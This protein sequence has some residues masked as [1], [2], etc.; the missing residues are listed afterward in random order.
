M[1][2]TEMIMERLKRGA[3]A[4]GGA[5]AAG[6]VKGELQERTS[7]GEFGLAGTEIAG[8]VA[9]STTSNMVAQR[10]DSIPNDLLEYGGY[11]MQ[12]AGFADIGSEVANST[13]T[14]ASRMSNDVVE[15][16]A[17]ASQ[18]SANGMNRDEE[19]V[20]TNA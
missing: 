17:D 13:Q 18:T 10:R 6:L 11:G 12:A 15:I 19:V 4:G 20:L 1:V 2:D 9:L 3:M 16:Q 7:L 14:G 8:G 5:F